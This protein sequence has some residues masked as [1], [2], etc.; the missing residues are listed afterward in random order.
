M[1]VAAGENRHAIHRS[2]R[3]Y[4]STDRARYYTV[5]PEMQ[6]DLEMRERLDRP[7]VRVYQRHPGTNLPEAQDII[8]VSQVMFPLKLS[9]QD[10]MMKLCYLM[11]KNIII[12]R[13]DR[14][15]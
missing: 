11:Q 1:T 13:N 10:S 9:E 5:G 15:K 12:I 2:Q 7:L 3:W 8:R 6:S 14:S 4:D